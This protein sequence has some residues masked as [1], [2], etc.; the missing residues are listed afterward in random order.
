[1]NGVSGVVT[2]VTPFIPSNLIIIPDKDGLPLFMGVW[3]RPGQWRVRDKL[4]E[5][6]EKYEQMKLALKKAERKNEIDLIKRHK[7]HMGRIQNSMRKLEG[8]MF[9]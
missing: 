2:D 9:R 8:M 4:D 5:L 3:E 1:M 6:W 7:Y